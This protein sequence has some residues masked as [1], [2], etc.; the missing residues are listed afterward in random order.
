MRQ[1]IFVPPLHPP[2]EELLIKTLSAKDAFAL[3]RA[4]I[5]LASAHGYKPADIAA[6]YGCS[7]Q[8]VRNVIHAFAARGLAVLHAGS[9]ARHDQQP[10]FDAAKL[11]ALRDLLHRSPRDFD[12]PTSLWSLHLVATVCYEQHLTPYGV[13]IE[14]IRQ[15]LGRLNVGWKRAKHW[16]TSPDPAYAAKKN[17]CA[18]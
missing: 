14:T 10:L 17:A 18:S 7:D 8:T 12:K 4:Q 1:P 15:A 6:L 5:I 9:T 13:S 2:E 16:I 11:D 3:R